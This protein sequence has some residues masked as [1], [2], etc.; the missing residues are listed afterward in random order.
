MGR[1]AIVILSPSIIG[2]AERRFTNLFLELNRK[3]PHEGVFIVTHS[4]K[5]GIEKL[6]GKE[7]IEDIIGIGPELP[8]SSEINLTDKQPKTT[9]SK[10]LIRQLKNTIFYKVYY[11]MKTR[12]EKKELFKEIKEIEKKYKID[13]YLAVYNGVLPLYF[14]FNNNKK[15]PRIVY[16]NMDSWF[17]HLTPNPEKLWYLKYTLFNLAHLKSDAI[18]FLSPFIT[19]G[20][21]KRKIP[22]LKTKMSI[23]ACSFT[24]YSKC[25]YSDKSQLKVVFASRLEVDKSPDKFTLTAAELAKKYPEVQFIVAG[26]GRMSDEIQDTITKAKLPNLIFKGFIENLPELLAQSSIFVSLQKENNYPS[27]SVLEAMA[28]GNA[29]IATDVGDTRLFINDKNGWLISNSAEDLKD[30]LIACL[31]NK[32]EILEKGLYAFNYV[33]E[34]FTIEKALDYYYNLLYPEYRQKND[35]SN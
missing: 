28:C 2:G 35:H 10:S 17:S 16:V 33:R 14:Y 11:L 19:E 4:M 12:N 20:L 7:A 23:T 9:T 8:E 1:F 32:N 30:Q 22:Y 13:R 21:D 29:I 5:K 24:D 6:Y 31:D 15:R 26:K 34:H 25:F 3:K 18:D 27:Q